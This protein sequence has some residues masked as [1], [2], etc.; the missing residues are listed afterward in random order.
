[1]KTNTLKKALSITSLSLLAFASPMMA[2]TDSASQRN[3]VG[4]EMRD[5]AGADDD[6]NWSWLGLLGLL[7]LF[8]LKRRSDV[9]ET[10]YRASRA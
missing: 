10:E 1:M 2:Q 6:T 4:T 8:G 3:T 5:P 9:H 7:G